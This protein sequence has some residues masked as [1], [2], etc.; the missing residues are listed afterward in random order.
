[1][2]YFCFNS[3]QTS[4]VVTIDRWSFCRGLTVETLVTSMVAYIGLES[5]LES[6]SLGAWE[7][8][9]PG[10]YMW[11]LYTW[12]LHVSPVHLGATCECCTLGATCECCTPGS[13]M[14]HLGATCEC[15]TPGGYMWVHTG[16]VHLGAT[17]ESCTPGGYM[18][19]MYTWELHVSAVHL[20]ATYVHTVHTYLGSHCVLA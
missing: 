4:H 16:N 8:C 7:C 9:T 10:G 2:Q 20:G 5:S 18:W 17:C 14:L 6:S 13:Y 15:C 11:V 3:S 1:M 12:G 19:V